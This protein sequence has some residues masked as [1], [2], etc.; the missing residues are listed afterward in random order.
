MGVDLHITRAEHWTENERAQVTGDEWLRYVA[1]DPELH[2]VAENGEHFV[3]WTGPSKYEEPWLDWFQGNV[4]TK[5]PDTALY[6]KMLRVAAAL[7]AKVQDD[8]GNDY[9]KPGDWNFNPMDAPPRSVEQS[10]T[11]WWRSLFGKK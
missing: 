7:G 6:E 10:K 5:W 1:S 9:A 11:N 3:R 8:D 4:Y 2:L